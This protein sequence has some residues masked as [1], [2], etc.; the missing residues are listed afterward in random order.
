MSLTADVASFLVGITHDRIPSEV[1]ARAK[2]HILDTIGVML[3]GVDVPSAVAVR[4][5]GL[6]GDGQQGQTVVGTPLRAQ[7]SLAALANGVSAHALDYDDTSFVV[8]AH[9]SGAAVPALLALG[10]VHRSSGKEMLTAFTAGYEATTRL[11]AAVLPTAYVRGWHA[12]GVIGTICAT[13]SGVHMLHMDVAGTCQALGIACSMASGLRGNFGSHTKALHSGHAAQAAVQAVSLALAGFTANSQILDE[14]Y[15]FYAVLVGAENVKPE[16]TRR[17]L[18]ETGRWALVD[19]G[20]G[21]KLHPCNSAVLPG[22]ATTLE[23]MKKNGIAPGQVSEVDYGH[24]E[25]ARTIVPFDDPRTSAEAMYSMTHAIAIAIVRGKA[26]IREFSDEAVRDPE[27]AEMRRK[28][29]PYVPDDL[30][31]VTD[32]HDIPASH[33]AIR[34]KDGRS[35]TGF[36]RRAR[37]YPGGEPITREALL[38]KFRECAQ[39]RLFPKVVEEV[40]QMVDHLEDMADVNQLTEALRTR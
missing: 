16:A 24:T 39:G 7:A 2:A 14:H 33:V 32:P 5:S 34:L 17:A 30:K 26:G 36:R 1:R 22:I 3:A 38:E 28:V 19:P 4:S 13:L 21:I 18:A 11:G 9:T 27:V 20:V 8:V 23:L 12:T 37:A 29:R 6:L 35:F 25:L 10:Q 40:V 15:G 31:G